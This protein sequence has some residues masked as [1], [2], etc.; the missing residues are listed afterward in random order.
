MYV[1]VHNPSPVE[2][3]EVDIL[4]PEKQNFN[5]SFFNLKKKAFEPVL[6][7]KVCHEDEFETGDP[8]TIC[9]LRVKAAFPSY[10]VSV[11]FVQGTESKTTKVA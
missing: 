6:H 3:H 2:F 10:S 11:L 4:V 9:N 1:A 7:E 5:V 8:V